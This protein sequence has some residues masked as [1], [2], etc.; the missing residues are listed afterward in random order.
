MTIARQA[1]A[2]DDAV[3]ET[4]SNQAARLSLPPGFSTDGPVDSVA[5]N[6]NQANVNRGQLGDRQDALARGEFGPPPSDITGG[7]APAPGAVPGGFAGG[8]G[9]FGAGFPGQGPGGFGGPGGRGGPGGPGGAPGG[10]GA[11][12]GRG[13][14]Q[15]PYNFTTGYTFGGSMLD[16]APYQLRPGSTTATPTY[17]RQNI[18]VSAG[19]PV[20]IPGLYDG[21]RK[22]NFT[23]NYTRQ[24]RRDTL[25]PV[26]HS[27]VGGDARRRFLVA[28]TDAGRSGHR[29]SLLQQPADRDRSD[30]RVSLELPA[31]AEPAWHFT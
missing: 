1:A 29:R 10:R 6:G 20:K 9:G 19:G 23:F 16:S 4:E 21:T 28:V 24:S 7:F 5:V 22:T 3:T 8:R 18:D 30:I 15:R 17:N 27:S 14:Q 12:A 2:V 26:R 13:L 11:L 25:R 31:A